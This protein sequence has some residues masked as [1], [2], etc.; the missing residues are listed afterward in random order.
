MTSPDPT[1]VA[2]D[3]VPVLEEIY[4]RIKHVHRE[5][6]PNDRLV[7]LE[8]DSLATLEILLEVEQHFAVSLV[9]T[10]KAAG[11]KTVRDLVALIDELRGPSNG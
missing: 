11:I 10:P 9:E 3:V 7:D 4:A 2:G 5:L 6:R 1:R 8:V